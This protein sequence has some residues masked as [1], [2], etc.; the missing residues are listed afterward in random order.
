[1]QTLESTPSKP[2]PRGWKRWL[3]I[4]F[5]AGGISLVIM[6][7]PMLPVLFWFGNE[8]I[9]YSLAESTFDQVGWLAAGEDGYL[10]EATRTK[11]A[12]DLVERELLIGLTH[13]QVLE[14]LGEPMRPNPAKPGEPVDWVAQ[15]EFLYYLNHG[16]IDP[17][18]FRIEFD[19]DGHVTRALKFNS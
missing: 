12:D 18:I 1:M 10:S 15:S 4:A 19:A 2:R 16:L 5:A 8:A 17:W 9:Q 7:I 3:G 13:A 14:L 6:L 11:M